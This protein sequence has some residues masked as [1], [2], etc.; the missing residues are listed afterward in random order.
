MRVPENEWAKGLGSAWAGAA[1]PHPATWLRRCAPSG[2][3][4]Q[5]R[6]RADKR[7][8]DAEAAARAV[9]VAV[10]RRPREIRRHAGAL[11]IVLTGGAA[12]AVGTIDRAATLA[13]A[14]DTLPGK[15]CVSATVAVGAVGREIGAEPVA[16]FFPSAAPTA[17]LSRR[18]ALLAARFR[19]VLTRFLVVL[20]PP[21]SPSFPL[22]RRVLPGL[23][24][25]GSEPGQ[26]RAKPATHKSPSALSGAEGTSEGIEVIALADLSPHGFSSLSFTRSR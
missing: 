25:R 6:R 24:I 3:S 18:D 20:A 8:L 1:N 9:A 15:T 11:S 23:A 21:P 19:A 14:V 22:S 2:H 26:E 5:A 16:A 4:A 13:G 17:T 12:A 7:G 10:T